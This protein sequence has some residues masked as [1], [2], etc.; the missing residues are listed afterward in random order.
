MSHDSSPKLSAALSL[1]NL[2]NPTPTAARILAAFTATL[3]LEYLF[4]HFRYPCR[5]P[6]TLTQGVDQATRLYNKCLDV[7]AFNA[8]EYGK[9][10]LLLQQ[11]T[12]RASQIAARVPPDSTGRSICREYWE[13]TLFLWRRLQDT[14]ECHRRVQLLIR[15]LEMCLMQ[16]SY[17]RA[18][19]EFQTHLRRLRT[20]GIPHDGV[21][22]GEEL[23]FCLAITLISQNR[24]RSRVVMLVLNIPPSLVS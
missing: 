16:S 19:Y 23:N 13:W 15:H 21:D 18:E 11:V 20:L 22:V 4:I 8:R 10:T 12:V 5:S 17:S 3:I 1:L 2:F 14:V 7:R 24:R 9:L 6:T